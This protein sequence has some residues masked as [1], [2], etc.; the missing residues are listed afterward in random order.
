MNK[1]VSEITKFEQM[2]FI[3]KK[4]IQNPGEITDDMLKGLKPD[5]EKYIRLRF[6]IGC[7]KAASLEE[8]AAAFSTST[9]HVCNIELAALSK[10]V[11]RYHQIIDA[12]RHPIDRSIRSLPLSGQCI[13]ALIRANVM[14]VRDLA[15]KTER[16]LLGTPGVSFFAVV[17]IEEVLESMGIELAAYDH[18]KDLQLVRGQQPTADLPTAV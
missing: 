11:R 1:G 18:S 14:T 7:E 13:N 17:R 4:L 2:I 3:R 6:G 15:Q 8:V 10:L 12:S 16:E 9:Y 5:Q